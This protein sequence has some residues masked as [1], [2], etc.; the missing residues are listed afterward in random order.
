MSPCRSASWIKTDVWSSHLK[1][2]LGVK[3]DDWTSHLWEIFLGLK[4][5]SE[6]VIDES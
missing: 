3:T 2:F 4:L 5:V 6:Q 1:G